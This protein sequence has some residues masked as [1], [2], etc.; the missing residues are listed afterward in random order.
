M[1]TSNFQNQIWNGV[2]STVTGF[3]NGLPFVGR[4]TGIRA[5]AGT[6]LQMAI[7]TE[8]ESFLMSSQE[9]ERTGGRILVEEDA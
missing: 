9:F 2:G 8:H 3:R 7:S 6:D 1:V 4:M 5:R